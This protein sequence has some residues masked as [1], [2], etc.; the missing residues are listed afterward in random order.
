MKPIVL[1]V[2]TAPRS[3]NKMKNI[4]SSIRTVSAECLLTVTIAMRALDAERSG[5]LSQLGK[6]RPTCADKSDAFPCS[7]S[8][9]T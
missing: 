4:Q 5:S 9:L 8:D 3:G 7:V 1:T 6:V 2:S